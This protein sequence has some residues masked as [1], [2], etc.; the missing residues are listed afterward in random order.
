MHTYL[1]TIIPIDI[2]SD[3]FTHIAFLICV[4]LILANC[5]CFC[6]SNIEENT[7]NKI[8]HVIAYSGLI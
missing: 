7:V 3:T 4:A 5:D 8:G 6:M 2:M 1:L